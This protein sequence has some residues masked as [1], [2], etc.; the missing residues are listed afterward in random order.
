MKNRL[1]FTVNSDGLTLGI[2][3]EH[4]M[5]YANFIHVQQYPQGML[6]FK[7]LIMN[8]N[9]RGFVAHHFCGS[10]LQKKV[11]LEIDWRNNVTWFLAVNLFD[12]SHHAVGDA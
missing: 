2:T 12:C 9:A 1:C 4:I 8:N 5:Y 3:L 10:D 7:T 6:L 11:E